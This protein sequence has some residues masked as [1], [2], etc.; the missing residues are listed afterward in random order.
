LSNKNKNIEVKL[1]FYFIFFF[2]FFFK[3][4]LEQDIFA[5]HCTIHLWPPALAL[6]TVK[7]MPSSFCQLIHQLPIW[8][9]M[10]KRL[11]HT[12][13][14]LSRQL[15]RPRRSEE[16]DQSNALASDIVHITAGHHRAFLLFVFISLYLKLY[17]PKIGIILNLKWCNLK[18]QAQIYSDMIK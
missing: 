11:K 10:L 18:A 12:C 7:A 9:V 15:L 8:S 3:I 14:W 2:F 13:I 4:Y 5:A 6:Y 17:T 16:L 1:I